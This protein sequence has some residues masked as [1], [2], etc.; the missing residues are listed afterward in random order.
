MG[1]A[2]EIP[3][4]EEMWIPLPEK[5][6]AR[7]R[8]IGN[9]WAMDYNVSAS[10]DTVYSILMRCSSKYN[11]TVDYTYWESYDAVIIDSINGDANGEGGNY[12]QYYVNGVYSPESCDKKRVS[13][14]DFIEWKFE[15]FG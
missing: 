7:M 1:T 14:G 13:N 12:W 3:R 15:E 6:C 8:I 10:N 11:F 2:M 4:N 9:G 5:S